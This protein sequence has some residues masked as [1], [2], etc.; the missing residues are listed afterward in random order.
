MLRFNTKGPPFSGT[1]DIVTMCMSVTYS[2]KRVFSETF[3]FAYVETL[4]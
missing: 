2:I 1:E 4:D 3:I